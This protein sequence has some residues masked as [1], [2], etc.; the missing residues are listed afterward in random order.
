MSSCKR[1]RENV[2]A[3]AIKVR[4]GKYTVYSQFIKRSSFHELSP[5]IMPSTTSR[6]IKTFT[7]L[8][9][10]KRTFNRYHSVCKEN[11]S[12]EQSVANE[13]KQ[14]MMFVFHK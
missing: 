7:V 9:R 4:L 5:Q 12:T 6:E 11:E 2:S 10:A 13:I 14:F 8:S 3:F 1:L